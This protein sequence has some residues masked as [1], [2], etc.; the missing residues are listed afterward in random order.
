MPLLPSEDENCGYIVEVTEEEVA[1]SVKIMPK[2][3]TL[4][5]ISYPILIT[6]FLVKNNIHSSFFLKEVCHNFGVA[7]THVTTVY[8]D[9][10]A[11]RHEVCDLMTINSL[12]HASYICRNTP[13]TISIIKQYSHVPV[14]HWNCD[15]LCLEKKNSIITKYKTRKGT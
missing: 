13:C 11:C 15:T 1:N 10:D 8:F 3:E 5:S 7:Q 2:L 4:V 9:Y 12:N 14:I 6:K